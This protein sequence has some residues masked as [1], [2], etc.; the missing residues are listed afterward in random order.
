[1]VGCEWMKTSE[2]ER[3][4]SF[5]TPDGDV[6]DAGRG[7]V[8][9]ILRHLDPAGMLAVSSPPPSRML[10]WHA[11]GD[12]RDRFRD[13]VA[14]A[15]MYAMLAL[16]PAVGMVWLADSLLRSRAFG[17]FCFAG[18][19]LGTPLYAFIRH[20]C[21]PDRHHH[22]ESMEWLDFDERAWRSRTLHWDGATPA[23]SER[24][25]LLELALVCHL[26]AGETSDSYEVSLFR[27]ADVQAPPRE[28]KWGRW[29]GLQR[30]VTGITG[31]GQDSKAQALEFA[32]ALAACWQM[33]CW[34]H[35]EGP[36]SPP[37]RV[38]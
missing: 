8:V 30:R 13:A 10:L 16:L 22:R 12:P 2:P 31:F 33:G 4:L 34:D 5:V 38:L 29:W 17:Q 26:E 24:I 20:V 23:R 25:P 18:I 32:R 9:K 35:T 14:A 15:V 11:Q 1:M 36:M 21:V 28:E 19:M 27:I 6:P 7:E 37:G 3:L